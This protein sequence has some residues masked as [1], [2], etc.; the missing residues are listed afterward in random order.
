MFLT[1]RKLDRRIT[2]VKKYRYRNIRNLEAFA[3]QEDLQGV[4]NPQVPAEFDN[5]DTIHTG[6]CWSGR[7]RYLWMHK[8]IEI[9]AQ[10]KGQRV[11][12]IFDFGNTGAG[13]NSGFEAMCYIDGKPY[14]GVD[15]N[16]KE[17]F[18]PEELCGK[19]VNLTF[20]LWSGLEGGGVP[21]VQEHKIRQADL[22]C[23]DEL[24]DDDQVF[25]EVNN[26]L[27]DKI[28][29]KLDVIK[30]GWGDYNQ[31]MQ[32]V[33]NTGDKWDLCFTCSWANDYLQNAQ[34]GAFLEL[35]DLLQKEGKEMYDKIDPRFWEAAKVGGVTYGVPSEKEIGSCP[36]WVFTKEYVDKYNIPYQDIHTLEDLEPYL[37]LIKE[38]EPDVVPMY[39]TKDYT[40]PTYMDKIQ[41]PVGIEYGDD[42]LTVKNVFET[43][44]MK[45]TL[46]TMRKY[47][48]A[49]Y[50]NKD[51]A[52]A[53][54]DKSIKRFVTKGDG[55]PYA[56][57]TWG[58]DLG[59]EVVA[60]QIM[61]TQITNASARGALTAIN[62]NSE[63]PEKAMEL[64]NLI[65]TDQEL[66]NMLNYGIEGVHWEKVETT[67]E[68][69]D[70]AAG[71]DY[72]YDYK[73][74]LNPE[75][76]KDYSAPYWVQ[77]GL[78]N[79]YV[80][81]N[82]PL[83]KWATFKEFND[84]SQEAPSFGFDFDL[85]PVSTQV[86]GFRN[87]LDEFGKSLYTGSV[88]PEEYLPQLQKKLEATGFAWSCLQ[89]RSG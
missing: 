66:R 46:D 31:K 80:M 35:D 47:Y 84:A 89:Y 48:L 9:P 75:K 7:D 10:W 36:M 5:W 61:D 29:V 30:V 45:S 14:Q 43:E 60:T 41:D 39:L 63:H 73:A 55:Q 11:V 51:A 81:D 50:I 37:K 71:K 17:V 22:A 32:V 52:T 70:A 3:V 13:N 77:G 6:D 15:V 49:G 86:A 40:A 59:Y 69:K 34:K 76:Q 85:E 25:E 8:D 38:N 64:L 33:I 72:I 4:V 28:G 23:L 87:V 78:F 12:G 44:R 62:K 88:D 53:S 24:A 26:Y 79:T 54:D 65:N 27:A 83:D 20:R 57:L 1:D 56:E 74:K 19:T 42:T 2:E 21:A 58:K 67:Q 18:F 68:E 82:E 16:H